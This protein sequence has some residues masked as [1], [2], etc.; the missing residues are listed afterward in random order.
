LS[1]ESVPVTPDDPAAYGQAAG[2]GLLAMQAAFQPV[3]ELILRMEGDPA[4]LADEGW[5]GEMESA[6]QALDGAGAALV[7][8]PPP[9]ED[10]PKPQAYSLRRA[11][12]HL[13]RAGED[14]QELVRHWRTAVEAGDAEAVQHPRSHI[15]RI[16][17]ARQQMRRELERAGVTLPTS[18]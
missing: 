3:G 15:H 17:R 14:A 4:L 6:L 9:A 7:A 13:Q 2:E 16:A 10:T 8:L 11:H 5:K 1:V 18:P 12:R